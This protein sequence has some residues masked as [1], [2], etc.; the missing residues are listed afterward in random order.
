MRRQTPL[1]TSDV[2]H[3]ATIFH[4]SAHPLCGVVRA[5]GPRKYL[6]S[7]R[8]LHLRTIIVVRRLSGCVPSK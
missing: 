5:L 4:Q 2:V 8:F 1:L 7:D 3:T 6:P